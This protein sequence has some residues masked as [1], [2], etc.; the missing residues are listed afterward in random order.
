MLNPKALS[1]I[2]D[3]VELAQKSEK[4]EK[5]VL[6]G[7]GK[8]TKTWDLFDPSRRRCGYDNSKIGALSATV[9]LMPGNVESIKEYA[10]KDV[11]SLYADLIGTVGWEMCVSCPCRCPGCYAMKEKRYFDVMETLLL[12]TIECWKDPVRFWGLVESELF[13]GSHAGQI[14]KVRIHECGEYTNENEFYISL[15]MMS[16][17][18]EM[19]FFGYSKRAFIGTAYLAGQIP[20]NVHFSCSPWITRDGKILCEP[21]GDMHQYIYDDGT[22]PARDAVLHCYCSNPDGTTNKENTCSNCLRCVRAVPGTK[23][24]VYPHG[25]ALKATWLAGRALYYVDVMKEDVTSASALAVRDGLT[26]CKRWR[27]DDVKKL[28]VRLVKATKENIKERGQ[29]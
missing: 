18:P 3:C 20:K 26:L 24:A 27:V 12:N 21:V 1:I 14:E 7:N 4:R 22:D 10:N 17:H 13:S 23:T 15:A 2:N 8:K 16:R 25:V 6:P 29:C 9:S 5:V 28:I 19:P 11:L